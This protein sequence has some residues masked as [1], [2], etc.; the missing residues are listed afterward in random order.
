MKYLDPKKEQLL[1]YDKWKIDT[2]TAS[3]MLESS[4]AEGEAIGLE[5]G[6]VT[7]VI[8]CKKA[9]YKLDEISIITGLT[10]EQII[11]ILKNN[12]I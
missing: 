7:V 9:G 5:K 3:S 1:Y 4:K 2:M 11:E 6:L 10:V 8:N 12:N